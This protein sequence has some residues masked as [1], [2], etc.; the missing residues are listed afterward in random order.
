[1]R[2]DTADSID[3]DGHT[4]RDQRESITV[5]RKL[6][7]SACH[8][9]V[10][11]WCDRVRGTGIYALDL[12][13]VRGVVV[14]KDSNGHRAQHVHKVMKYRLVPV[15]SLKPVFTSHKFS[16]DVIAQRLNKDIRSRSI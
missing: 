9:N 4:H 5:T 1:V 3:S 12:C 15:K 6:T 16:N 8:W 7:A 10:D 14:N 11:D 13:G 2:S